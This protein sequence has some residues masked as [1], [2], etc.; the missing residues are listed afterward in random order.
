MA[1]A[2]NGLVGKN[3]LFDTVRKCSQRTHDLRYQ[4]VEA[5][6]SDGQ[7]LRLWP[8][9]QRAEVRQKGL[10]KIISSP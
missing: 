4:L 9:A 3:G 6:Y 5:A 8:L 10:V 2:G 7:T 1:L